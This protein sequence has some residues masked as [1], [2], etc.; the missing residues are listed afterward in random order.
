MARPPFYGTGG[1]HARYC[2][3]R[4]RIQHYSSPVATTSQE[5]RTQQLLSAVGSRVRSRRLEQ[6]ATLKQLAKSASLSPR[7]LSQLEAGQANIAIG[8]LLQVADALQVP[9][10]QLLAEDR[11]LLIGLLGLRGAGKSTL[12][13]QIAAALGIAFVELDQ[14]I[15]AAA[16]L[17]LSE[18]FALHGEPYYRRLEGQCLAALVAEGHP[19]V[20]ALPGGI[21]HDDEAFQ[22]LRHHATS[23]WL[24]ATPEDHMTRV[25]AQGD[26]RPMAESEDAMAELR[27]ILAA[28]EPLYAQ[29]DITVDTSAAG[30]RTLELLLTKLAEQGWERASC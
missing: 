29:A 23:V 26:Q 15:E 1:R 28:R 13:P 20:V 3:S 17:G 19:C 11:P 21:V 4:L 6:G 12:G 24:R 16:G 8:R 2:L 10:Q 27:A 18:L 30:S 25:L 7:F 5:N 22:H 9:L 14:R